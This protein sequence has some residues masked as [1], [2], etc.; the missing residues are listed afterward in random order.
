MGGRGSAVHVSTTKTSSGTRTE[1]GGIG[2]GGL[3]GLMPAEFFTESD[4]VP[5]EVDPEEI[6]IESEINEDSDQ[7]IDFGEKIGGARK[8]AWKERGLGVYDLAGMTQIEKNK[9]VTKDNIW[10]IDNDKLLAE[11]YTPQQIVLF[12]EIKKQIPKTPDYRGMSDDEKSSTQLLYVETVNQIKDEMLKVKSS[13]DIQQVINNV[14]IKPGYVEQNEGSRPRSTSKMLSNHAASAELFNN[15]NHYKSEFHWS[16]LKLQAEK[17]QIGVSEDKKLPRGYQVTKFKEGYAVVKGSFIIS[18]KFQNEADAILHARSLG[19]KKQIE[20]KKRFIPKQL[21]HVNRDGID[22]RNN[23]DVKGKNYMDT[24][25]FRGG[26]FGE[27]LTEKDRKVSMNYGYDALKDLS[28]V[29]NIKDES[30]AMDGKLAIAFGS[31]GK[32]GAAAHYEPDRN[33]INLTKMNGAGS[34]AHEWFH[35]LDYNIAEKLGLNKGEPLTRASKTDLERVGLSSIVKLV[36]TMKYKGGNRMS[37]DSPYSNETDFYKNSQR[38]D[39]HNS[40]TDQGYWQSNVELA[41]RA[42]ACYITD[43][44]SAKSDYLSGTSEVYIDIVQDYVTKKTQV[45][46]A[47]PVGKE[48]QEINKAFDDLF[49][50]LR[51]K[52][53]I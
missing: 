45:I 16:R 2:V 32:A 38:F 22:Y 52:K 11:G 27:W 15:L 3:S 12:R 51:Q 8:D 17:S 26:E 14:F 6:V 31:R 41:A 21:E 48:R 47:I 53:L 10:T 34:L 37:W 49:N 18:D 35:A 20:R 25:K 42:F 7:L 30:I 36:D 39:Q 1:I 5:I 13:S 23:T 50:D 9:L 33:V 40:K 19:E 28:H 46:Q 4:I 29:L 24:F 44:T 43:K